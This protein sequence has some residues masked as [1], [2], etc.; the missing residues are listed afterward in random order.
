MIIWADGRVTAVR[1]GWPGAVELAVAR[2]DGAQVRALA[3]TAL[4]APPLVGDRVLMNVAALQRGL[5][6]GGY[7]LVIAALTPDGDLRGQPPQPA[8]HLVKARYLPQ[9]AMVAGADEQG[10]PYHALLADADD[11]AGLPVVVA[12]LHSALTP[13]LLAVAHDRPGT[14]VVY[15]M[16][17]QGALPLAFS[18]AVA[19][20]REAGL[21]AATVT[22]GQAFGGDLE[23][24]TVH[25]GLLAARLAL[26]ADL[27]VLSQGPGNLGTGTRWGFSGVGVGEAVNAAATLGGRPVGSLRISTADARP[28]HRG[29]SH[30]S[31]TAYGRVALLPADLAVPDL[32]AA[33]A[34]TGIAGLDAVVALAP[35]V[36]AAT[37]A[38]T[39]HRAV[40]VPLT[41]L[42]AALAT[43]PVPMS[44][45]GRGLDG[46]PAYFLAAAAA[47]RHAAALVD[48]PCPEPVDGPAP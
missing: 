48:T 10:S 26:G 5:G 24:V 32:A 45:M 36:E 21:L 41:G 14:R 11:L 20:L 47:G 8:G 13:A 18:R 15:V 7:A 31:V 16:S 27:V 22:V 34:L 29:L 2:A 40:R 3:Y 25:S 37:A 42:D 39:R 43:S 9:Q 33:G 17:D 46:D 44:T 35:E 28:R 38:L 4:M 12:D 6:T 19:G 23:A 1:G 30:H